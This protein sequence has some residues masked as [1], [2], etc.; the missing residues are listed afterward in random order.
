[1]DNPPLNYLHHN[2]RY[3]FIITF[4]TQLPRSILDDELVL[5]INHIKPLNQE[6][7]ELVLGIHI[8][9]MIFF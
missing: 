4:T 3:T 9:K 5:L 7:N 6:N 8:S 2:Q 1:M